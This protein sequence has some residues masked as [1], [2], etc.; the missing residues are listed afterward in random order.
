M[1]IWASITSGIQ[2]FRLT[3]AL[4][5]R[6][7]IQATLT[8]CVLLMCLN[9]HSGDCEDRI[10]ARKHINSLSYF[11]SKARTL[12][13][14][15]THEDYPQVLPP[16]SSKVLRPSSTHE[17]WPHL[18]SRGTLLLC[19]PLAGSRCHVAQRGTRLLCAPLNGSLCPV[20]CCHPPTH[21]E[22]QTQTFQHIRTCRKIVFV[23]EYIG[24]VC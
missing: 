5:I 12:P 9:K 18:G 22:K 7:C 4:V 23:Y 6:S 3:S 11:Y 1:K 15:S 21:Q 10:V 24:V 8:L 16:S 2:S 14:G 20:H 13:P 19:V 17:D